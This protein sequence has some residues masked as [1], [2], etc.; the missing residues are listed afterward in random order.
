MRRR[1]FLAACGGLALPARAPRRLPSAQGA[2]QTPSARNPAASGRVRV[3]NS[4]AGLPPDIVGAFREPVA[5]QQSS[6]GQY[7]VFDRRAHTVYG[8]DKEMT[9][10]WKLVQIGGDAGRILEPTAFALAPNGTFV[11]ADRPAVL[12]RVQLFGPGGDL[13]GGFTIPGRPS[14]SVTLD[15]LVLNGIGSLQ[16]RG[17]SILINQPETGALVSDYTVQ[18]VIARTFGP[19]RPTGHE[20]DRDVHMA[21]NTGLPLVNPLGGFYFVFQAGVPLFRKLDEAGA[22]VFE[23]H[24][25][26]PE[27]DETIKNLPTTWPRRRGSGDRLLPVVRPVVRTAAVDGA[28]RL[29]VVFAGLPHTYVYDTNGERTRVVQFRGAGPIAPS[30]LSFAPDGR[31]L[32]TPGCYMFDPP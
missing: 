3:L 27:L 11:V 2:S 14:E 22:L 21:L 24:I 6:S 17:R 9:G 30:G 26:G 20:A 7:F 23:R 5:F 19:L 28:G 32:V 12:E 4:V 13:L 29:W 18:G 25:E 16:Y 10:S 1:D 8:I 31:L 15:G